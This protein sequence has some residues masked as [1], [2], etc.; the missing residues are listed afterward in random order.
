MVKWK[1]RRMREGKEKSAER[2]RE[3]GRGEGKKGPSINCPA[4]CGKL[5][6]NSHIQG[7]EGGKEGEG[8]R[9]PAGGAR[10]H[11][12]HDPHAFYMV[13]TWQRIA[14]RG[15]KERSRSRDAG[16]RPLISSGARGSCLPRGPSSR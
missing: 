3:G 14:S 6:F 9:L 5:R 1:A 11:A 13:T 7:G 4:L 8:A 12:V 15:V 2:E 10:I 16:K